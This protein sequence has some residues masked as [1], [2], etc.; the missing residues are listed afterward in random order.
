MRVILPFLQIFKELRPNQRTILL[1]HID[2]RSCEAIFEAFA[3]VLR[4][5]KVSPATRKRLKRSLAPHKNCLRTI[6][7]RRAS[8]KTKRKKL[9]QLG[10]FPFA[11]IISAAIPLL[12]SALQRR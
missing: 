4:N 12:M 7:N 11:A 10:G 5:D 9:Q 2:D 3:N 6:I 8:C 1:S